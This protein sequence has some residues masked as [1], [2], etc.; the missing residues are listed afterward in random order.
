M[1]IVLLSGGSG[2]RLWPLSNETRSKIFLKLLP[3]E[4]GGKESMI[5]RVCRQL[6]EAGLLPF[7]SIVAHKSQA[8]IVQNHVGD[9]IPFISEPH[10]RGTYTAVALASSYLHNKL[11]AA[12]DETVVVI[13]ADLFVEPEFFNLLRKFPGVLAQSGSELALLGTTPKHASSQFGYIVPQHSSET[14][15]KDYFTVNQFV[16]KPDVEKALHLMGNNAMWNCGVFAF[17]LS[18]MLSSLKSKGLPAAYDDLIGCYEHLPEASFDVEVVEKTRPSVVIPYGKV[19]KDLGDWSVLPDFFETNVTGLGEISSDSIHTHL[20][21]ELVIPIHVIGVSNLI[22]A[23]SAD[24][25]LVANKDKSN[26][27]KKIRNNRQEPMQGEKRW[28][29]YRI[30]DYSKAEIQPETLTKKVELLPGK[31]TSYHFHQKRKEIWI[32]ISGTGEFI[33]EAV[34][35]QIQTGDVLQIPAGAKHAVKAITPIEYIEV[36]IGT[37]LLEEDIVRIAMTW[38]E[39]SKLCNGDQS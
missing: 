13:P 26:Q 3:S 21:N 38:E 2:K 12:P 34:N 29:T 8:E 39:I 23:A 15:S 33:M 6:N 17:P 19:W 28:G 24:G 31:N 5:Q 36:Q 14:L 30:F 7:T 4:G 1:R 25:I 11:L 32:I 20:V 22:V 9:K 18:F 27:I 16:E 37:D 10:R 35:V